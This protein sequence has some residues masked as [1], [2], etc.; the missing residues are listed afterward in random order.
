M[1]LF[2]GNLYFILLFFEQVKSHLSN[3]WKSSKLFLRRQASREKLSRILLQ[4]SSALQVTCGEI[5]CDIAIA[6]AVAGWLATHV[7]SKLARSPLMV[8]NHDQSKRQ[9]LFLPMSSIEQQQR[10]GIGR[11]SLQ[12]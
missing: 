8:H 4:S 12:V 1:L 9:S 3:T 10:E 7:L 6:I 11:E 5:E 2:D